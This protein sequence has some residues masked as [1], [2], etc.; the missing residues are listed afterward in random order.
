MS[1][2]AKSIRMAV[3][4]AG[5]IFG[6]I[7]LSGCALEDQPHIRIGSYATSSPGTTF[8]DPNNLGKHSYSRNLS[9]KNGIVYT[10]RGG[11]IDI[12]HVRI[13]ADYVNHIYNKTK[14]TLIRNS[15]GFSFGLNTDRSVLTVEFIYPEEWKDAH[16][17]D[18]YEIA[19]EMALELS[20]YFAY[21]L[22][23]W[24]EI[25][26]WYG[27]K[28]MG[29]FP[30]FPSSFSWED[31]YSNLLGTRLGAKALADTEH[32]FGEAMD[33]ALRQ[34]LENLGAQSHKTAKQAAE[35]M[36]GKWWTGTPFVVFVEMKE[37]NMDIGQVD[38]LITPTLVPGICPG[39]LPV[40]YPVP[41]KKVLAKYGFGLKFE[42]VPKEFEKEKI[43]K[44]LNNPNGT[45]I[46]ALTDLP[47]I[48]THIQS[49][50]IGLGYDT[51]P[52]KTR[53]QTAAH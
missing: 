14:R 33:I 16:R 1:I 38:G 21:T 7:V 47:I 18:K 13:A 17:D 8:L 39:S 48:M 27:Y 31:N 52:P 35:K 44:I 30:E 5:A 10:C 29:V 45:Y 32:N 53:F 2:P 9:E 46:N 40:S 24:H 34:E 51:M 23:T 15:S 11:H 6:S 28:S 22:L 3:L 25:L 37:R 49:E 4:I 20:Q 50:A 26:T 43:F 36:K 19:D 12:T 41:T 42:I